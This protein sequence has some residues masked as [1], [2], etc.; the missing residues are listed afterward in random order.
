M[1]A[2]ANQLADTL[3]WIR[4]GLHVTAAAVWVG[5]QLVMAGL[6]PAARRVSP[7]APRALAAAFGRISWPAYWLL[8]VTGLWN[9]AAV[10]GQ[11]TSTTWEVI[12]VVKIVAVV[13]AGFFAWRHTHAKSAAARGAFA[14]TAALASL[15]ALALGVG[16]GG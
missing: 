1:I 10:T 15:L 5:G 2:A 3:T 9:W 16:L 4:L 13:G 12:F 6:V 8:V 7:E 14:G 11:S